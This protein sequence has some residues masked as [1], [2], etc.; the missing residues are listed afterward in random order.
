MTPKSSRSTIPLGAGIDNW[1]TE[2][3]PQLHT[4]LTQGSFQ[5]YHAHTGS[6]TIPHWP[7]VSIPSPG[8]SEA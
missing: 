1:E 5:C 8:L 7:Q 2:D 6:V 4:Y 3:S